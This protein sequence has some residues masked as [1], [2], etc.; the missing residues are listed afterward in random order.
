[1]IRDITI[2][3]YYPA[4]SILHRLDPRV[5]FVGTIMFLVSLFVA[6]S[7]WG[8]LLA[9]VF[10]AA[11]IIMSKV[12]VKFMLKGLKPLFFIL[13][14]TV[15]FNLFLIPGKVLWQFWILRSHRRVSCRL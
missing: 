1:M 10:L 13:L 8:Y 11:V 15:A 12:P 3:Q 9:T 4:D 7:F 14:I 6:N 5:K 2:G